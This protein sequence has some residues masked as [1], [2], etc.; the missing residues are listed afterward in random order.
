[1]NIIPK[2]TSQQNIKMPI[3]T[4]NTYTRS[5]GVCG[6]SVEAKTYKTA[7][8]RLKLHVKANHPNKKYKFNNDF[9]DTIIYSSSSSKSHTTK[10]VGEMWE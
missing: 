7:T 8:M 3:Y 4:N 5:C 6:F 9:E 1:M 10:T 2:K